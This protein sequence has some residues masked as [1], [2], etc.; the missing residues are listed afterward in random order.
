MLSAHLQQQP[1]KV[2]PEASPAID[3]PASQLTR[4]PAEVELNLGDVKQRHLSIVSCSLMLTGL[5]VYV[6]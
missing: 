1:A 2:A 5:A 6:N 3:P 4:L